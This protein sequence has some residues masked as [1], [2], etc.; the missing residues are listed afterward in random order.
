MLATVWLLS[1]F[2]WLS[3]VRDL[4]LKSSAIACINVPSSSHISNYVTIKHSRNVR[5]SRKPIFIINIFK[6]IIIIT[7]FFLLWQSSPFLPVR[8]P[9][10]LSS[11]PWRSSAS[12]SLSLW[13]SPATPSPYT[14]CPRETS[15]HSYLV[16][17]EVDCRALSDYGRCPSCC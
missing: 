12:P 9:A 11:Y 17:R 10:H 7:S 1:P 16:R 2:K 13:C 4:K 6:F 14:P 3:C 8:C 15:P 5:L